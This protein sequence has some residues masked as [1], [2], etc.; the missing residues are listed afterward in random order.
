MD[1]GA[2]VVFEHGRIVR[3]RGVRLTTTGEVDRTWSGAP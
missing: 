2:R 3:A 1:H